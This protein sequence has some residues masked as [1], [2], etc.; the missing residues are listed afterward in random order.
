MGNEAMAYGAVEAGVQVAAGYPGTPSS[1]ILA[2]LARL[3]RNMGF[4]AEWSV[5]EKVALEVAAGAALAGARSIVTM[6]QVGLNV[7]ADPLMSLAYLGVKGGMVVVSADDPGPHSSQNEQ[8]TRLFGRFAKLPVLDPATPAEAKA[9]M[10][11]AFELSERTGLPVILRPTTRV[12]HA[13]QEVEVAETLYAP[14]RTAYFEKSLDWVILP[15][16][17]AKK[18]PLLNAKQEILARLFAESPFNRMEIAG[19]VGVIAGGLSDNYVREA[20]EAL[21]AE[22]SLLKIGTPYPLPEKLVVEFLRQVDRV[23]VVEEQ[24][25]VIEEQV[26]A[27]A[28]RQGLTLEIVG[29][30]GGF[31]PREGELNVDRVA[32]ALRR[33]LGLEA[34]PVAERPTPPELP[35]R[36]PVLCAGCP[37]RASFY[38]LRQAV[39]ELGVDAVFNGDIGCYTLGAFPP[40][41]AVDT[42]LCMGASVSM[43]AGMQRAEPGRKHIAVL[44]DSTFFHNGIPGLIDAVYNQTDITVVILDNRTTAMTGHQPHPGTGRTA[45]GEPGETVDIPALV[46]ACGV[47]CLVEADPVIPTAAMRALKEAISF[48]GPAVVIMR[49]TCAALKRGGPRF[50]VNAADCE[51]C[52]T[53]YRDLGCPAIFLEDGRPS[54][55][56]DKCAGCGFCLR[57]CPSKAITRVGTAS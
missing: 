55:V 6:K 24:E 5:N 48:T 29:K 31:V 54:I 16:T 13:C 12:C 42:C 27:A 20:L 23:L 52:G 22:V 39:R 46:R 34:F 56:T 32:A 18:H 51:D 9:M 15:R 53:C 17:A 19:R 36:G 38:M 45:G 2:T 7:A 26:V 4:Y 49:H 44:G 21:G 33:F 41:E 35:L 8:D 37:H 50:T 14:V 3:S 28:Y 47:R 57:L 30:R 43:A 10:R 25:P 40:L 1:E 11:E